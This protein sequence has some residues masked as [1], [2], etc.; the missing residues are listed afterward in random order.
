MHWSHG[1]FGYGLRMKGL[2]GCT[3]LSR[4]DNYCEVYRS[5]QIVLSKIGS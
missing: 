5:A 4:T 3:S 1:V 2:I